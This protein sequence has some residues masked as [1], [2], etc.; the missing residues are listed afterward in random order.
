MAI[1]LLDFTSTGI[2]SFSCTVKLREGSLTA[3]VH[4]EVRC[5][6]PE[7]QVKL[8]LVTETDD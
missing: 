4:A 3:V 1:S 7:D 2:M 8:G 6:G 5:P